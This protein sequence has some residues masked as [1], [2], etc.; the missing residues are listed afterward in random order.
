MHHIDGNCHNNDPENLEIITQAEHLRK[1][2][3]EMKAARSR[4]LTDAQ[5]RDIRAS[6][7]GGAALHR[8]GKYNALVWTIYQVK[9]GVSYRDVRS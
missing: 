8:S 1:H 9:R 6:N 7:L 2:Y 5:V 3:P 4:K